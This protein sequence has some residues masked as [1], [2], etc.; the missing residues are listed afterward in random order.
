MEERRV[1]E[2]GKE[3]MRVEE[4]EIE[5]GR[6]GGSVNEEMDEDEEDDEDD[7][8]EDVQSGYASY[9]PGAF[10]TMAVTAFDEF[11]QRFAGNGLDAPFAPLYLYG[12]RDP[13]VVCRQLPLVVDGEVVF[14]D[15]LPMEMKGHAESLYNFCK[16]HLFDNW[17]PVM[18][19]LVCIP[20]RLGVT[21]PLSVLPPT[22]VGSKGHAVAILPLGQLSPLRFNII[23]SFSNVVGRTPLSLVTWNWDCPRRPLYG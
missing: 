4:G 1:E 7:D 9:P 22:E 16:N 13:L 17:S 19:S 5:R 3:E 23:V 10:P 11:A 8:E 20:S 12:E 2:D 6:E 15:H 18:L 21:Q 14:G